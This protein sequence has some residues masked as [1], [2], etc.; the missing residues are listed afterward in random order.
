MARN[1]AILLV[2]LALGCSAETDVGEA[3]ES[4]EATLNGFD[5]EDIVLVY[6]EASGRIDVVVD[7][8]DLEWRAL[9]PTVE[10]QVEVVSPDGSRTLHDLGFAQDE[11]DPEATR[12]EMPALD[13]GLY[14][15]TVSRWAIDGETVAG[16]IVHRTMELLRVG[17]GEEGKGKDH[18]DDDDD[19]KDCKKGK[20]IKGSD[21]RDELRGTK[22]KDTLL[23]FDGKDSLKGFECPDVL[24]GGKG[25]DELW[26]H[27]GRDL[28]DGGKGK[29]IC[30][31]G[32]GKDKFIDCEKVVED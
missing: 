32:K 17:D 2:V 11:D 23:G 24:R 25:K 28:L 18:D 4:L 19:D 27:E 6:D 8:G 31:G 1:K 16:P 10:L 30:R 13:E 14:E 26:G 15:V 20:L 3:G 7:T 9:D 12:V 5:D 22:R 29:D 21:G